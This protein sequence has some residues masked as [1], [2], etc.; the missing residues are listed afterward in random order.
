MKNKIERKLGGVVVMGAV[1]M[2]ALGVLHAQG[3]NQNGYNQS[4]NPGYSDQQ[5]GQVDPPSR[6]ARVSVLTGNVSVQPASVDQF[7]VAETNYPMTTGDRI[8]ADAGSTAEI[9]TGQLAVRLGQQTDL[10][11]T[12]MT[13]ELAQFGLAQGSVHLRSFNVY[14][15]ETVEL[16]TP[17]VAVTVLQAGDVRVDV[18]PNNDVTTV[19]VL[20]GQVQVNGNGVE[21]VLEPG[22]RLR[23]SGGNPV[24]AQSIGGMRPDGLDRFSAQRDGL[25]LNAFAEDAQYVNPGTIGGE[26]LVGYGSWENDGDYGAVWY[27]TNVAYDW[28]P[29]RNGHWTW[30]AP[31][32]WTWIESEPWGFAP[33]H[34]G[35]WN[36]FGNRWGWIPGP[37]VVRPV[38]S[39]AL[40]VFVGGDRIGGGVTAWFPLGPREVYTPWYH[41]SDRYLN[42]VNVSN[43]YDRNVVQVRNIYNQRTAVNTYVN[44]DNRSYANRGVATVAMQRD[45]FARGGRADQGG[46]RVDARQLAQAPVLPHPTVTPERQMI[47]TAP[48]RALP[49]VQQRPVLASQQDNRVGPAVWGRGQNGQSG[50]FDNGRFNNGQ[51]P[52]RR[53]GGQGFPQGSQQQGGQPQGGFRNGANG[54][55]QQTQAPQPPQRRQPPTVTT[56][57][58]PPQQQPLQQPAQQPSQQPVQQGRQQSPVPQPQRPAAP[59]QQQ[60]TVQQP[61]QQQPVQQG[62]TP[63]PVPQPQRPTAPVQQPA[64][65]TVQQQQPAQQQPVQQRPLFNQAVPPQPRP[66]FESQRQ[67]IQAND[68]GRPLSPQQLNNVRQNLPV[69]QPE[70]QETPHPGMQPNQPGVHNNMQRPVEPFP[71]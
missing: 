27:P 10:T 20:S 57:P 69:G 25:Y 22:E 31:W 5:G 37:S 48:A 42:R 40:V 12:A 55:P 19:S 7:N 44:V 59:V 67:A 45:N 26:D 2:G 9:Q 11:V 60:Q 63:S 47:A 43:I 36:R 3:Y 17:N 54:I 70:R 65:Q 50:Q 6:V 46:V 64:Q 1:L 33:F 32:G 58:Q 8:Y 16:D 49:P 53:D 29:Y 71:K 15:G 14:Q 41:T 56:A 68:P 62:R 24:Y 66:S 39:P 34:Y 52:G 13:D 61:A 35:R 23:L 4:Y 28:Q 38:Y 51:D 30:V 18:D 21:E